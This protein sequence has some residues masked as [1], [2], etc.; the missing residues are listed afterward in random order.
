M[1]A[2]YSFYHSRVVDLIKMALVPVVAAPTEKMWIN[3]LRTTI[4]HLY[5][6]AF[7]SE[8]YNEKNRAKKISKLNGSCVDEIHVRSVTVFKNSMKKRRLAIS[9][10]TN[11]I[12]KV[13]RIV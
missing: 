1:H 10:A 11:L 3:K 7:T 4:T 12:R 8:S 2:Q 5:Q 6:N 9:I 13:R